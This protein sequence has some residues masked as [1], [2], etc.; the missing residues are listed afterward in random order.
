MKK[1][2]N[3]CVLILIIP[4]NVYAKCSDYCADVAPAVRLV[5]HGIIPIF[6]IIIPIILIVMGMIDLSKAVVAGKEEEMKKASSMFVKRCLYA[7]AIFFVVTIVTLIMNLFKDTSEIDGTEEWWQCYSSA[8]T[9]SD[10]SFTSSKKN[11]NGQACYYCGSS[12][13]YEWLTKKSKASKNCVIRE[14]YTNQNTCLQNNEEKKCYLCGNNS[15]AK[16]VWGRNMTGCALKSEYKDKNTCLKNNNSNSSNNSTNNNNTTTNTTTSYNK[17][18]YI[19]DSRTVGMCSNA[20]RQGTEDC[21]IAKVGMGLN[22]FKNTAIPS[23]ENK[24]KSDSKTNVVINMGTNDMA[25]DSKN[26]NAIAKAYV[27]QFNNLSNKYPDT[28]FVIVSVTQVDNNKASQNGYTVTNEDAIAF[29][30]Y[31][32]SHTSSNI[33]YC[34]VYSNINGKYNTSDGIHYDTKTY[35]EIYDAIQNCL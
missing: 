6:Q 17:T 16:Y 26:G 31:I 18:I 12:Q 4:I 29:N 33:K 7:V 11:S 28:K 25:G 9:C 10:K 2:N 32:K 35:Q 23:L 30:S 21:D 24:L 22:W 15:G 20:N 5:K 1:I 8:D 27:E 13:K 19:G 14:K 34:D 3:L